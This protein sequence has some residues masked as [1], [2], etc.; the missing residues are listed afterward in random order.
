MKIESIENDQCE[1]TVDF[2]VELPIQL[3]EDQRP[4][5]DTFLISSLGECPE[6]T[7][8]SVSEVQVKGII[9][10]RYFLHGCWIHKTIAMSVG[11][12]SI[13]YTESDRETRRI[14][15]SM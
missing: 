6:Y 12:K 7:I 8:E 5:L 1:W 2:A 14:M 15:S 3:D 4:V 11:L 13:D 9:T 10:L